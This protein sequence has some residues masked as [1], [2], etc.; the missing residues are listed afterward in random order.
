MGH[1]APD[2]PHR[3][4]RSL[5]LSD[6]HLGA[7]GCRADLILDFLQRNRAEHYHLVG[8]ILDL[9][10]SL[11]PHWTETHQAVVDH[12][13]QRQVDGARITYVRGNHDPAPETAHPT[14]ALRVETCLEWVHEAGDGRRY[15]IIHGDGQDNWLF[16]SNLLRRIGSRMDHGLRALDRMIDAWILRL[17]DPQRG[18]F[19]KAL[20]LLNHW[21]YPDRAHERRLVDLARTKGVDGVICG[22][23][24]IAA[25]HERHGLVY[26][27]CGDWLDSFTA[28]AEDFSG[29]L[30]LLDARAMAAG[31]GK[32]LPGQ[33]VTA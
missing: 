11:I 20:H 5:F 9:W 17:R 22:H 4:H 8:D 14:R 25:L 26:G 23:F 10:H 27:N 31:R 15:L 16:Q 21:L 19:A 24:H 1:A 7:I 2:F 29:R 32:A 3:Q 18:P 33:A 13:H 12:L 6:L 30:H 28:L